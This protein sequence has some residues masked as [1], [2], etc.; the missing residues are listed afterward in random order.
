VVETE[1]RRWVVDFGNNETPH[2]LQGQMELEEG[3]ERAGKLQWWS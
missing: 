1:A 2:G 3:Q